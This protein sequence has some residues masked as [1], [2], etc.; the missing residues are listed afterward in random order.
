MQEAIQIAKK[1]CGN[2]H[3]N[4]CVGAVLVKN[5]RVIL[6]GA[7]LKFGG[8]HAE[9][10]AISKNPSL[11]RG[12]TLY[13]TLEPCAH[14]GKTPPCADFVARHG[15][16]KVVIGMQ[17]PNPLVSGRGLRFLKKARLEVVCG[18]LEKECRE[19]NKDFS[20]WIRHQMPYVLVKA[21]QSLD[22][23]IA[24]RSGESRW[25]TGSPARK[26]GHQ[27]RAEADAI[28]VGVNTVLKD[29]PRLSARASKKAPQPLKVILDS[30][31]RT[32]VSAKV[33]S[34]QS[35]APVIIFTTEAAAKN[36]R[37]LY[38]G[39]AEI[40]SVKKKNG[41]VDLISALKIL[42]KRGVVKLLIEGGG[43]VISSAFSAGVVK[44]AYFF[45]APT[46]IG[47]KN[48]AASV[49]GQGAKRMKDVFRFKKYEIKK[50]G[51]DILMHGE[52]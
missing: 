2:V 3:P 26:F 1:G 7:H 50:L 51:K 15:I 4:P 45:I 52:F 21:A 20:H 18:V 32:P 29:N 40:I 5:G 36:R 47:G 9:V 12:A 37:N 30:H 8:S 24:T 6:S 38:R 43:E 27:L 22:G 44:E 31:L 11:A 35:P 42:G 23:K 33:F 46:V 39:K 48:A 10:A 19:L 17:D 14:Y 16:K 13:V 25:I 28:L 34:R 41:H 49:S